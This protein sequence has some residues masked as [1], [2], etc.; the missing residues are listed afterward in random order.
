MTRYLLDT[1]IISNF[2]KPAPSATLMAWMAE[3]S[4]ED[5]F[6][7]AL[8]LAELRRS[9]LEKPADARYSPTA[10]GWRNQPQLRKVA[11]VPASVA[12]E[13]AIACYGRMRADIEIRKR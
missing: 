2:A 5:L 4:D 8:T 10:S 13:Q 6:I 9:V 7:S 11:C 1:N 3:Q 12:R